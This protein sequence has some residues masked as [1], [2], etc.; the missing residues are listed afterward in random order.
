MYRNTTST[1]SLLNQPLFFFQPL[2]TKTTNH[3]YKHIF[4]IPNL[5]T[6]LLLFVFESYITG[7]M[8]SCI[9]YLMGKDGT[10]MIEKRVE[11]ASFVY[12]LLL[13]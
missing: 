2:Y 4:Q 1:T 13:F 7:N 12:C 9:V 6:T 8:D 5:T 10:P 11:V 3:L